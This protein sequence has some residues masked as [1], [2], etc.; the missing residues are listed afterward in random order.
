M[1]TKD[2][3][4]FIKV[5]GLAPTKARS[6]SGLSK[7]LIEVHGGEVPGSFAELG[8]SYNHTRAWG[9]EQ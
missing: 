2:I 9:C 8:G 6:L 1:Q 5:L 3:E 4:G 7:K